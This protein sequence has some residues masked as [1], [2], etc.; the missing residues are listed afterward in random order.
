[1]DLL[2]NFDGSEEQR[3][4]SLKRV[5][6]QSL[7]QRSA[8]SHRPP[9]LHSLPQ[10]YRNAVYEST[11]LPRGIHR[12]DTWANFDK[13]L[14]RGSGRHCQRCQ[15]AMV[16][17]GLKRA[18]NVR[19][20]KVRPWIHPES[21]S[22][23]RRWSV[24]ILAWQCWLG[25]IESTSIRPARPRLTIVPPKV[26]RPN[27][28]D[29]TSPSPDLG[30]LQ[31]ANEY[32][33]G[34]LSA[35]PSIL[36]NASVPSPRLRFPSPNSA[37]SPIEDYGEVIDTELD[38]AALKQ[39]PPRLQNSLLTVPKERGRLESRQRRTESEIRAAESE[40]RAAESEARAAESEARAAVSEARAAE[41]E[42]KR[43]P[44]F[45]NRPTDAEKADARAL[46]KRSK[47]TASW[48]GFSSNY[49]RLT[50]STKNPHWEITANT[51]LDAGTSQSA[52]V[53]E[54]EILHEH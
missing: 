33:P 3:A 13:C 23:S 45:S 7:P 2:E 14:A 40:A 17:G 54:E 38:P 39:L 30:P 1:M 49:W 27:S 6:L 21:L 10:S 43:M 18:K 11:C 53:G 37:A 9:R 4:K 28:L 48:T 34:D 42:R 36:R 35:R 20:Q 50:T 25:E 32:P 16:R 26:R 31:T 51:I 29:L 8:E 46:T 19:D 22:Y 5:R 47:L 52:S 12:Q 41:I 24:F 44:L 15:L